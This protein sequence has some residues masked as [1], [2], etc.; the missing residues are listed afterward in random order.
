[1]AK[2]G[3]TELQ[4]ILDEIGSTLQAHSYRVHPRPS[5]DPDPANSQSKV[6]SIGID[7]ELIV[8]LALRST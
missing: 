8:T 5:Q 6:L 1:M 2:L 7:D 4:K 3:P